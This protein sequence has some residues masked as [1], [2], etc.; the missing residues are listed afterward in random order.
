MN[1]DAPEIVR[2][3]D[4]SDPTRRGDLAGDLPGAHRGAPQP[5][6]FA[7]AVCAPELRSPRI[8]SAPRVDDTTRLG[9]VEVDPVVQRHRRK[10]ADGASKTQRQN[11]HLAELALRFR[12][13]SRILVQDIGGSEDINIGSRRIVIVVAEDIEDLFARLLTRQAKA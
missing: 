4:E 12:Y 2:A 7:V 8:R 3:V 11:R 1:S 10:R 6:A 5:E 13:F 9:V